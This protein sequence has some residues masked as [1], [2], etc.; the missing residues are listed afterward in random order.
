MTGADITKLVSGNTAYIQF[1]GTTGNTGAGLGLIYYATDGK[2]ATK[3]PNGNALKGVWVIKDN[4]SCITF[5]G[6]PPNP[7]TKYDK[8]GEVIT[9]I[10]TADGKAR[11][12]I[13]KFAAGNPEKL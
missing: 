8:E 1:D 2:V 7:C 4:T 3:F 11:G 12:K 5:E 9:L 10:N 6:R 13:V